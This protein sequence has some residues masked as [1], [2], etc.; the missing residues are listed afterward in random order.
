[1]RSAQIAQLYPRSPLAQGVA[2]SYD[3]QTQIGSTV[4]DVSGNGNNGT[5]QVALGGLWG[6]GKISGGGV[7]NGTNSFIA[8]ALKSLLQFSGDVPFS[9]SCWIKPTSAALSTLSTIWSLTTPGQPTNTSL[10][11]FATSGGSLGLDVGGGSFIVGTPVNSVIA[12][13]WAHVVAIKSVIPKR[14]QIYI[15][16]Q[17][18]VSGIAPTF[19]IQPNAAAIGAWSSSLFWSGGVDEVIWHTYALTPNDVA[20]LYAGG[21][22]KAYPFI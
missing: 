14:L 6:P 10:G 5:W 9:V 11:L 4:F 22:G 18:V 16:N 15:N 17:L 21:Q 19:N 2:A 3:F 8:L 20:Q 13:V 7:F 1:M 12:G